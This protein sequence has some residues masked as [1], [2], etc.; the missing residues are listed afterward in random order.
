[1]KMPLLKEIVS[2]C[3]PIDVGDNRRSTGS[4]ISNS[5]SEIPNC[6]SDLA[7]S[8]EDACKNIEPD[9]IQI[10]EALQTIY[11]DANDLKEKTL[12]SVGLIGTDSNEGILV[13]VKDLVKGSL[14]EIKNCDEGLSKNLKH[15]SAIIEHLEGLYDSCAKFLKTVRFLTV[16]G[17]NIRIESSRSEETLDMFSVVTDEI[18]EVSEKISGITQVIRYDSKAERACLASVHGE[19]SAGLNQ[20]GWLAKDAEKAVKSAVRE[21]EQIAKLSSTALELGIARSREISSSVSDVVVEIQF[22]DSMSQRIKHIA[23][24]LCDVKRMFTEQ[25]STASETNNTTE[26]KWGSVHSILRLQIAQ[27]KQITSEVDEVYEKST[28]AFEKL[29]SEVDLLSK[30]LSVLASDNIKNRTDQIKYTQ[31]P[32][33][34]LQSSLKHLHGILGQGRSLFER[35]EKAADR[36]SGTAN[37]LSAQAKQV[38]EISSDTH[39]LSLNAILKAIHLGHKGKTLQVLAQ[40][41]TNLSNQSDMF[42]S[43]VGELLGSITTLSQGLQSRAS[44][45]TEGEQFKKTA[46]FSIDSG[47]QDITDAYER[48]TAESAQVFKRSEALSNAISQTRTYLDFLPKLAVTLKGHLKQLQEIRQTTISRTEQDLSNFPDEVGEIVERYTMQQEREIHEEFFEMKSDAGTKSYEIKNSE[49]A[50]SEEV[51]DLGDNVELF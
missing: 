36:A 28:G 11:G 42:V 18:K 43:T 41:M 13:K 9:F 44:S 15:I 3:F 20:L 5:F 21:I 26:E 4:G 48:F 22:H 34:V 12:Q 6:L 46:G 39:I 51:E 27:L 37:R 16:L 33:A 7:R 25:T 32:L 29:M 24:A 50:G 2:V 40:E 45:K 30:S 17:L 14:L 47:I 19:I 10:G 49:S 23:D 35:M 38:Q 8:L 1:M 31:D